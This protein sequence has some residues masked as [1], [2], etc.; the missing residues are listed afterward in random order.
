MGCPDGELS[1]LITDDSEI[2]RLNRLYRGKNKATDVLSFSLA[3]GEGGELSR[4]LGDVVISWD[5]TR[6]QARELGVT[7]REEFLRLLVHGVLHLLGYDHEN[8]PEAEA[9]RMRRKEEQ[10]LAKLSPL[11]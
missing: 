2:K 11:V 5:T 4:L 10:L 8:V 7:I 9:R 6:R 1:I 3:E